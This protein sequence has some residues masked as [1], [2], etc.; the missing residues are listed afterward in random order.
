MSEKITIKEIAKR[1]QTSKTTVSFYLNGKTEKMSQQT[2]ERIAAVIQETNYRPSFAARSLNAKDT[3]LIGVIIGDITN[4]FANQ[5][6]KGID[7][8]ARKERYQLIVGSSAYDGEQEAYYVERMLAM[9]VDGFIIQPSTQFEALSE[10]IAAQGK[11]VVFID[12]QVSLKNGKW[13]KTNSYEA[14]LDACDA[15]AK[16]QYDEFLIISADPSVLSTRQERVAGF[17]DALAAHGKTAQLLIVDG[18]SSVPDMERMLNQHLKFGVKTLIFVANCFLL[19]RVYLALKPYRNLIPQTIGLFG[20]DNTEW[21]ALASP[22]VT[23][24]VQ[25]AY[26]EGMQAARILIDTLSK[27]FKEA[28]NQ[29]LKC[30]VSWQDSTAQ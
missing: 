25:P 14:I 19:P 1:A 16:H 4:A 24:I 20:I 23:T 8:L 26:E 6:V 30:Y 13:V 11:E 3:R 22:S 5:I 12:S 18:E 29:I 9:G 10:R 27:Q 17:H 2:Q 7:D 15:L 21:S 28:P